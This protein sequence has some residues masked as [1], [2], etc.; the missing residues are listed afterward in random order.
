MP[1]VLF[2][3]ISLESEETSLEYRKTKTEAD[4]WGQ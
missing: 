1:K 4:Y 3:E 2:T